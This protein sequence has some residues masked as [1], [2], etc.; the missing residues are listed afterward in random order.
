MG[1]KAGF[2]EDKLFDIGEVELDRLSSTP[3]V[4]DT[5]HEKIYILDSNGHLHR[6][7]NT[8][9]ETDLEKLRVS[10]NATT[11]KYLED[12]LYQGTGVILTTLNEGADEQVQIE[13]SPSVGVSRYAC[14]CGKTSNVSSG[15][16]LEFFRAIGSNETPFV[17]PEVS[18][19]K[20]MSV[21]VSE[22]TTCTFTVYKNAV[23]LDTI[24]ITADTLATESGLNW[25]LA[26]EDELSVALTSGSCKDPIFNIF[27]QTV[28]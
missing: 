28:I 10:A 2:D 27:V 14:T 13:L 12:A 4:P 18:S 25:S 23:L 7:G 22:S 1:N 11:D 24:T 26:V 9:R 20:A 15:Q 16:Y 8:E 19:L 21:S 3:T 6:K 17:I 5:S